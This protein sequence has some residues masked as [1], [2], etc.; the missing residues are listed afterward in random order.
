MSIGDSYLQ[1]AQLSIPVTYKVLSFSVDE[2]IDITFLEVDAD[3][4]K[5]LIIT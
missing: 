1:P 4:P 3:G 5:L 2:H